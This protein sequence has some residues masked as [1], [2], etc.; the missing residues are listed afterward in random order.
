LRPVRSGIYEHD[1]HAAAD[2]EFEIGTLDHLVPGNRGRMLDPRR[3]PVTVLGVD[4]SVA[5]F[6]LVVEAFEDLGARWRLPIEDVERFQFEKRAKRLERASGEQL[7]RL[8]ARFDRTI[9]VPADGTAREASLRALTEE[10]ARIGPLIAAHEP[11]AGLELERLVER[12]QGSEQAGAALRGL[13]GTAGLAELERSFADTYVSNPA[14]GEIVKGHAIVLAEMG[15][16]PYS[17]PV[18]RDQALFAGDGAKPRRRR[19]ILLRLAFL[20][21]LMAVLGSSDVELFRGLALDGVLE[22]SRPRSFV[23]ASFS[24]AVATAH[25]DSPTDVALLARQRVPVARLFMTFLE[26]SQMNERYRE[27]EAVL[28]G[29]PGN[30]LF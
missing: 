26:T 5:M 17:G 13:L 30:L 23:A 15:L 16:C 7:K 14:S 8:A 24:R 1:P 19:H 9:E 18:V 25:F 22:P 2:A 4:D 21:E 10:R 11:L 20:A 29:E 6:E 3:T 28:I 27:A 12:R